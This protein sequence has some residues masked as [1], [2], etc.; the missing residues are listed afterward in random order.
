M[1][2]VFLSAAAADPLSAS[3]WNAIAAVGDYEIRVL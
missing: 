3:V 2:F 1:C